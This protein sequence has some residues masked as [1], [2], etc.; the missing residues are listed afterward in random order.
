MV[1]I[2]SLR[3]TVLAL[4]AELK[5]VVIICKFVNFWMTCYKIDWC[6]GYPLVEIMQVLKRSATS[7]AKLASS[8][9]R[10]KTKTKQTHGQASIRR[11][12]SQE[13]DNKVG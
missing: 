6:A 10:A 9:V 2:K 11:N 8:R 1:L 7:V 12:C 4:L 5:K 13:Q 3:E